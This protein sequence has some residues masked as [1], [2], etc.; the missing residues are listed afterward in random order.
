MGDAQDLFIPGRQLRG[1]ATAPSDAQDTAMAKNTSLVNMTSSLSA[2]AV[3][4]LQGCCGMC[5]YHGFC[6]PV[7][8]SCYH[9]QR[10]AYYTYCGQWSGGPS[11]SVPQGP[12]PMWRPSGWC[13]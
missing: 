11:P 3:A 1:A 5:P 9:N 13:P 7:S 6:S 10:K 8:H 12:S 4:S 2:A